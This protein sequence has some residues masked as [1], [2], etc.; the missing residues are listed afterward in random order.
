MTIVFVAAFGIV[1]LMVL[2]G[3]NVLE[4][5]AREESHDVPQNPCE[6]CLRWE[7]CN[8]VDNKRPLCIGEKE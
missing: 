8:G 6:N 1:L 4:I 7:E 5:R 2:A 3:K